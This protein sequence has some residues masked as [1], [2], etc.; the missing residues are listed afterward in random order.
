MEKKI[1]CLLLAFFLIAAPAK[2]IDIPDCSV[3]DQPGATYY[4]TADIIDSEAT[5][6]MGFWA[7][8]VTLDCQGHTIDGAI[9]F[10]WENTGIWVNN[11]NATIRNCVITDW[12]IG[13]YSLKSSNI[14]GCNVSKNDR[15]AGIILLSDNNKV[16]NT[17]A[18]QNY[19]GIKL[20]DSNFNVL[21][22][23]TANSNDF[24][25]SLDNSNSN[26]LSNITVTGGIRGVWLDSSNN[27]TLTNMD[28]SYSDNDAI[29]IYNSFENFL[30]NITLKSN[31]NG[32]TMDFSSNNTLTGITADSNNIGIGMSSSNFTTIKNSKIQNSAF[33]GLS[34]FDISSNEF[35]N[36]LF[37]NTNN[38][39][40]D[41][42]RPNHWNTTK[43]A[44]TRIYPKG[45]QIGGNYWTNPSGDGYSDT[46]Y[47]TDRDGF[48]DDAYTSADDNTDYM[49]LSRYSPLSSCLTIEESGEYYL[50]QNIVASGGDCINIST[51]DVTL[52]CNGYNLTCSGICHFS[53]IALDV[54]NI[55]VK[56]CFVYGSWEKSLVVNANYSTFYNIFEGWA[57]N[58]FSGYNSVLRDSR[59]GM[60]RIGSYTNISNNALGYLEIPRHSRFNTIENNTITADVVGIWGCERHDNLIRNNNI[61][62]F[63]GI[64]LNWCDSIFGENKIYNNY[65]KAVYPIT[66]CYAYPDFYNTTRQSGARIFSEGTEIGGNYWTNPSGD[67]YSDTC[68]DTDRD[69]F[70]DEPYF[71]DCFP[72]SGYDYLPLSDCYGT[73]ADWRKV[74]EVKTRYNST[75][76]QINRTYA[77]NSGC[78]PSYSTTEYVRYSA[79]MSGW[80]S[81]M[82]VMLS[83]G[84]ILILV[85]ISAPSPREMIDML[86]GGIVVAAIL[87]YMISYLLAL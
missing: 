18:N 77:D 46:C 86:I 65:I 71:I 54:S 67:G 25:I 11:E 14:I 76:W 40:M 19:F 68:Y 34:T 51:N 36:N 85:R 81:L 27:N 64:Q 22:N 48:C 26:I 3:L 78:E 63:R 1:F 50:T 57:A 28:I 58:E 80:I 38:F 20:F 23:I 47:D 84:V 55:T 33:Y 82:A 30:S 43:Q 31:D 52:D 62:G 69:G 5:I 39:Y 12:W 24:G 13:I 17:S 15:N 32:V 45:D 29:W 59:L 4:L 87:I 70:C 79:P 16:I 35:Y 56:N 73:T 44:G 8:N 75:C 74:S 61:S 2:A 49:P 10:T 53:F 42:I 6:C 41:E 9:V 21:S 37:N 66:G 83:F 60:L 72:G 7:D